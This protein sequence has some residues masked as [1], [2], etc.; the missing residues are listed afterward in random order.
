MASLSDNNSLKKALDALVQSEI[1]K[2]QNLQ[3]AITAQ[4]Y[5]RNQSS[6]YQLGQIGYGAPSKP[7]VSPSTSVSATSVDP[8]ASPLSGLINTIYDTTYLSNSPSA[9]QEND[10]SDSTNGGGSVKPKQN[11]S[12]LSQAAKERRAAGTVRWYDLV[13]GDVITNGGRTLAI[14]GPG[15]WQDLGDGQ[16][17]TWT[18]NAETISSRGWSATLVELKPKQ[19]VNFDSVILPT[20]KKNA[21]IDAIK[22]VDNHDLIFDTWGFGDVFEKGTAISMLFWGEPGT[23]K[24]LM[25]QAIADRYDYKLTTISTAEVETPEPGGAERNIQRYFKE[26][27]DKSVLLFDECDSLISD[28]KHLGMIM[29]AQVNA[30]LT[31]LETHKGVV[32]FTTNRLGALDPAFDRRLSLK[33]EFEMPDVEHRIMIWKR[34]FPQQ[35]PVAKNLNWETFA[36][37]EIAGGHIKNVVLRA[38]RRA[39]NTTKKITND[40]VAEALIEELHSNQSFQSAV[41]NH[42]ALYGQPVG[43]R[44]LGAARQAIRGKGGLTHG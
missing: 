28:R 13:P 3:Q 29:A 39:A 43:G 6:V 20:E 14:T 17:G 2:N 8:M 7:S 24:T 27:G 18:G 34:M 1:A 30:L 37:V 23:G 41:Q 9:S 36:Q 31:A 32:I 19:K 15:Q 5:N 22:Q 12:E 16:F 38:A 42:G 35:A 44:T 25:A 11:I 40:I 33:L 10:G 26:A 21:I 4:N